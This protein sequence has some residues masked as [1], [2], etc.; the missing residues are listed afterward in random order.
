MTKTIQ[1]FFFTLLFIIT[2]CSSR[3]TT[4]TA[5]TVEEER[6]LADEA[7]A[8]MLKDYPP[9]KNQALQNYI[10]QL[11]QKIVKA[12]N[13][14]NNPYKYTFTVVDA[15]MV[16]AFA[17]PAGK[18]FITAPII[19]M[20]DSEAEIAG[21]IGH[22]IGHVTERHTAKRMYTAKKE[23]NKMWIFGG[24]GAAIGGAGGYLLADKLCAKGDSACRAKYTVY[25][26][27]A[28]GL[29]GLMVQKYGFMKNSQEDE[30][31]SDR[32][33]FKYAANAG[34]DK[35]KVGDFYLKLA[36]MEKEAKKGQNALMS[37]IG[38]AM[39]SHPP[40]EARV[41]QAEK[42]KGEIH[43]SGKLV[44]SSEFSEMK[45]QARQIA[46]KK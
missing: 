13:L 30:L 23:Q 36:Q 42:L 1:I 7:M 46:E 28:G 37:W 6:K 44:S 20:A 11:G 35:N 12:N 5:L 27:G 29:G 17:L 40:S 34:Y 3:N 24:V 4:K 41:K 21:V 2:A 10:N 8:E 22:E 43:S 38:D 45:K 32:V 39:A 16:N 15:K 31:E 18:I 14:D 19:A 25:G 26:A 9:A 33:G